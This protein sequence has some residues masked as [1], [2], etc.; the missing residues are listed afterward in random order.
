MKREILYKAKRVDG[1]GWVAGYLT[2]AYNAGYKGECDRVC[3][4]S[5]IVEVFEVIPETVCQFINKLDKNG[6]KIFEGDTRHGSY[7]CDNEKIFYKD[8]MVFEDGRFNWFTCDGFD[9]S[10]MPSFCET[11]ITGNIHDKK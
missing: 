8:K 3:I 11:E 7:Y 9:Y 1:E 6:K 2:P 10:G 4:H 5:G